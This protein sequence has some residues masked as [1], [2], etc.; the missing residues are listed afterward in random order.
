MNQYICN[1][2]N[3]TLINITND[4]AISYIC[5]DKFIKNKSS[6]YQLLLK[7]IKPEEY[8]R[9]IVEKKIRDN[10]ILL[11]NEKVF[12]NNIKLL[13]KFETPHKPKSWYGDIYLYKKN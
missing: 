13:K 12:H 10:E 5:K 2:K 3:F 7:R 8:Q 1:F 6:Y 9:I 4:F 11:L